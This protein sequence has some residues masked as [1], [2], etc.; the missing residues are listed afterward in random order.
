V[1][2][3]DPHAPQSRACTCQVLAGISIAGIDV[4]GVD[5]VLATFES[6]HGHGCGGQLVSRA[7]SNMGRKP[8][9]KKARAA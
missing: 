1:T 4:E 7:E 2:A 3:R 9:A 6:D 8:R 5:R